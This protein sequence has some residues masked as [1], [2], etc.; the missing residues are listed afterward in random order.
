[1]PLK[2]NPQVKIEL[3]DGAF[4]LTDADTGKTRP[5]DPL[6]VFI[7]S[8]CDGSREIPQVV[9]ALQQ[10]L[11]SAGQ[12]IPADIRLSEQVRKIVDA[13]SQEGVLFIE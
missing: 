2:I 12:P 8:L 1:M 11:T 5:I 9:E 7:C 6:A 3:K 10:N 4:A 13:L